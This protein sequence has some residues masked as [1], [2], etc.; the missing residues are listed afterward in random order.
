MSDNGHDNQEL[1]DQ[2]PGDL[3][4]IAEVVG[5]DA[6]VKI[7]KAFAGTYL[8]IHK[9]DA[10]LREMRDHDIRME[11]AQG[12]KPREL[13]IKNRL[14]ERQIWNILGFEPASKTS[15]DLLD[16]LKEKD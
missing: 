3:R 2:L 15:P 5:V 4:K 14:T 13:A 9:I 1:L 11:Y 6:A 16:L 7:A 12:K 10:F 8:Y